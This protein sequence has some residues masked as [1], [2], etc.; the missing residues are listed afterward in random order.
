MPK[1]VWRCV[2][3]QVNHPFHGLSASMVPVAGRSPAAPSQYLCPMAEATHVS[4]R[5]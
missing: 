1:A 3:A 5:V 4:A 2:C